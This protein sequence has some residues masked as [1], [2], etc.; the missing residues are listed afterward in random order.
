MTRKHAWNSRKEL[1]RELE[2]IGA[3]L[4]E[5]EAAR[6]THTYTLREELERFETHVYSDTWGIPEAVFEAT[7]QE[8]R[9]WI[10]GEY[11]GLDRQL[12]EQVRF[13]IDVAR[14]ER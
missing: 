3:D 1:L 4:S 12:E 8:V 7:L 11:G 14:F 13:A 2:A 5:V 6:F 9:A 10:A